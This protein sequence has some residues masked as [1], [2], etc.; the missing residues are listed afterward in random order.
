MAYCS[1]I[2]IVV[3]AVAAVIGIYAPEPLLSRI[4]W[5]LFVTGLTLAVVFFVRDRSAARE[6]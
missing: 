2:F 3:A 4:A 5:G 6:E 1:L